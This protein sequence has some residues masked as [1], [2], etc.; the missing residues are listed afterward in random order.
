ML[1]KKK[2]CAGCGEITYI[3]KNIEGERYCKWCCNQKEPPKPKK[4]K[5]Y[6]INP[7]SE[8]RKA[9]DI[10]YNQLRK[11]F[12]TD[13][14]YCM[15]HGK[16]CTGQA[17]E[18]H[19]SYSGADREKYYLDTRTWFAVCRVDHDAIHANTIQSKELGY[20]K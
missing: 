14:P 1:Q 16:G 18:I 6:T 8:K 3:W 9:Q 7:K 5:Y 13:H 12:L 11:K 4:Q 20:L 17:T 2:L 15:I 19:H 10:V